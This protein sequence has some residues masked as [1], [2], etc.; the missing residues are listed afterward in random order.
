MSQRATWTVHSPALHGARTPCHRPRNEWAALPRGRMAANTPCGLEMQ[1]AAFVH[2]A[3]QPKLEFTLKV[4]SVCMQGTRTQVLP[5]IAFQDFRDGGQS[6]RCARA[7]PGVPCC[8]SPVHVRCRL[9]RHQLHMKRHCSVGYGCLVHSTGRQVAHVALRQHSGVGSM[10]S[11]TNVPAASSSSAE[12]RSA[13][14]CA[15]V[16]V[17]HAPAAGCRRAEVAMRPV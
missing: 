14:C 9:R 6:S 5:A 13:W 1:Q 12:N 8:K 3:H 17:R 2:I 16:T 11:R 15:A 4:A 7:T 10:R